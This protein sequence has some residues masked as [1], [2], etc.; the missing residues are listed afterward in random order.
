EHAEVWHVLLA[1]VDRTTVMRGPA[2][3]QLRFMLFVA[4]IAGGTAGLLA[5]HRLPEEDIA[6]AACGALFALTT[7]ALGY[8]VAL[9]ASGL[10]IPSWV[11][12]LLGLGLI[13]WAVADGANVAVGSPTTALGHIALWPL[14]FTLWGVVAIVVAA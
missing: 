5:A 4:A 6:W 7:M 14:D 8:G 10:R 2:V 13:A 12:S 1:P 11:A 9:L 3:R